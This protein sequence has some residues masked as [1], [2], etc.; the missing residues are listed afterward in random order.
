[1]AIKFHQKYHNA[2]VRPFFINI[3]VVAHAWNRVLNAPFPSPS[4]ST[5]HPPRLPHPHPIHLPTSHPRSQ[6]TASDRPSPIATSRCAQPG[7]SRY[8]CHGSRV[9]AAGLLAR[10]GAPGTGARDVGAGVFEEL[11]GRCWRGGG[12]Y[13]VLGGDV[14][15]G[16]RGGDEVSV[17]DSGF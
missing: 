7:R 16:E 12:W 10:D 4:R 13:V 9:L 2:N 17:L 14:G 11:R 15:D 5:H 3:I 8:N 6:K 1:M